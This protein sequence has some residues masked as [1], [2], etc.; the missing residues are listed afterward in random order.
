MQYPGEFEAANRALATTH[1]DVN[2]A[3]WRNLETLAKDLG[4]A[5]PAG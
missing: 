4:V 1:L 2:P 5:L 3:I